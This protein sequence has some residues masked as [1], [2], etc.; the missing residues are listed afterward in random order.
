MRHLP[1]P[2]D[3]AAKEE[4]LSIMKSSIDTLDIDSDFKETLYACFP[5]V[6]EFMVNR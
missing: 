3:Q 5:N 2:I 6:A 4:W 1:H